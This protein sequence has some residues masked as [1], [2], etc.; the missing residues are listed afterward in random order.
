M[1]PHETLHILRD[2]D[3]NRVLEAAREGNCDFIVTGDQDLLDLGKYKK[4]KIL[5]SE[6]FL[7]QI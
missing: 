5:T 4:I 7:L 6:E 3:D 2:E 1:A